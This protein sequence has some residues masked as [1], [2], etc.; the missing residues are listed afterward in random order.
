MTLCAQAETKL[1][2]VKSVAARQTMDSPGVYQ[3][4]F[5][6]LLYAFVFG[7]TCYVGCFLHLGNITNLDISLYFPGKVVY[8]PLSARSIHKLST[9]PIISPH[10]VS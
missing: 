7:S 3:L 6:L 4:M 8:S 2:P 10:L 5:P 1:S 9:S